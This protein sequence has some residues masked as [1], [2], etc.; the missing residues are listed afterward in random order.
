MAQTQHKCQVTSLDHLVLTVSDIKRTLTFYQETL[1][2]QVDRFN[3][4]DGST[5]WALKFGQ[6]KINLHQS[7]QEFEPKAARPTSGSADICFVSDSD[8]QQ[9]QEHFGKQGV[10]IEMGPVTRTG[11]LGKLISLYIRDPDGNLIEVAQQ[12]S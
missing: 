8:I 12:Q 2:M 5:R 11:A 10:K 9:W 7:G 4:A 6:S 1:G 3:A